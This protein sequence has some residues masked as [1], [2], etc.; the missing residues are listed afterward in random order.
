MR[1]TALLKVE[2]KDLLER[3]LAKYPTLNSFFYRRLRPET[4]PVASPKDPTVISSA[5]DCRITVFDSVEEAKRLWIKGRHFTLPSL[6]RDSKLAAELQGGS[7]AIFRLAVEDYHRFHSPIDAVV[8]ETNEIP[9]GY[10]TVNSMIVRDKRFNVFTANKRNI[11]TL[12]AKHPLTHQ[13][14]PVAYCQIGALLVASIH[15]TKPKGQR[16]NRGDELGYFAYGGSTIIVIFPEG[17]VEWNQ[18]LLDNSEGRNSEGVQVET[19]VKVGEEIGRWV[20]AR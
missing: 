15:Q 13:P 7:V 18:D 1:L 4:R 3:D 6:L 20:A 9:G 10:F 8:G 19:L 14:T 16:I 12:H 17:T 2:C 5:A 11:T